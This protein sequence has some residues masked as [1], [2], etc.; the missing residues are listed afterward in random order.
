MMPLYTLHLL[1][2]PLGILAARMIAAKKIQS[3]AVPRLSYYPTLVIFASGIAYFALYSGVGKAPWIAQGISILT[4]LLIFALFLIK[5]FEIRFFYLFGIFSFEIY[6]LHWP[7]LYRY[8]VFFKFLP[9]S[10]ALTLYLAFFLCLGWV[11]QKI[12]KSLTS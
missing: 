7:I 11:L 12:I 6:L 8:D 1:A 3:F 2:F 10:L 9:A 5:R 4:M